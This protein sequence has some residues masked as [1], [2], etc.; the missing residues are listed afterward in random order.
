MNSKVFEQDGLKVRVSIDDRIVMF[1]TPE[2]GSIPD[3]S[4][5]GSIPWGMW[6]AINNWITDSV[7]SAVT[8]H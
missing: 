1:T 4:F 3:T 8:T 2:G 7:M 5:G 6:H